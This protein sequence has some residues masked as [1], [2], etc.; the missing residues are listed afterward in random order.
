[1]FRRLQAP[2]DHHVP[3]RCLR[4]SV[5]PRATGQWVHPLVC[6]VQDHHVPGR[7]LRG[8]VLPRATGQWVHPLQCTV[9]PSFVFV[10]GLPSLCCPHSHPTLT[11]GLFCLW[12]T[13][14]TWASVNLMHVPHSAECCGPMAAPSWL[15]LAWTYTWVGPGC[16][17]KKNLTYIIF[18]FFNKSEFKNIAVGI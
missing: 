6:T 5:L 11:C 13:F 12:F 16:E 3:G 15:F 8:S 4:G 2:Q 10:F 9:Q 7:C 17:C 18:D 14:L 1:M